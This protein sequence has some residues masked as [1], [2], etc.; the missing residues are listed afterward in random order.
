MKKNV[1]LIIIALAIRNLPS[2]T[3]SPADQT[4]VVVPYQVV[5]AGPHQ[6]VWQKTTVDKLGQTNIQSYTE[7]ATGLNFYDPASST[8]KSSRELF[9]I[10]KNGFAIATNGQNK[11]IIAPD[12]ATP[13]GVI[14]FLGPDGQRLLSSPRALVFRDNDKSAIIAQVTNCVGEFS[15]PNVIVFPAAFDSL[16]AAISYTYTRSSV[17]QDVIFYRQLPV[18]PA[19]FDFSPD[20]TVLEIW[21]EFL[22]AS[23]P[24]VTTSSTS[25][26]QA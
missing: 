22:Q 4:A 14:D 23:T 7:L 3:T 12:I 18:T 20:S 13:D 21:T 5:S 19:D 16:K 17:A 8:W 6:N 11:L 2:Q 10:T 24:V 15:P 26:D 25:A 9:E 1:I